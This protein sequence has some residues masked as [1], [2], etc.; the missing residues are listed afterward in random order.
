MFPKFLVS[1]A[2]ETL[3]FCFPLVRH[4]P[5]SPSYLFLPHSS[6]GEAA[7]RLHGSVPESEDREGA[8]E[9]GTNPRETHGRQ[10]RHRPRPH[11]P[12]LPLRMYYRSDPSVMPSSGC[13]VRYIG[14]S[15]E[16]E[17]FV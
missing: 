5:N 11:L 7:G 16:R 17:E 6:P 13:W 4:A 3:Y 1:Y 12:R 8:Q 9:G 14:C 15:E 2:L 10:T